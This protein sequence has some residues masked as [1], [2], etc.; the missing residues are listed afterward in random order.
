[1]AR[2]N[3]ILP[4]PPTF[5]CLC[6]VQMPPVFS[7]HQCCPWTSLHTHPHIKG[8]DGWIPFYVHCMGSILVPLLSCLKL[9]GPRLQLTWPAVSVPMISYQHKNLCMVRRFVIIT[10]ILWFRAGK[11]GQDTQL[12][13]RDGAAGCVIGLTKSGRLELRDNILLTL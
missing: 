13:Q 2:G 3:Q 12:S 8:L 11:L 4:Y 7:C 5:L 1:V 9:I 6:C 10:H